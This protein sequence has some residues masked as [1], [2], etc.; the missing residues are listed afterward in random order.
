MLLHDESDGTVSDLQAA[1]AQAIARCCPALQRLDALYSL[2]A[3]L[4]LASLQ[5]LTQLQ[6][7]WP[8]DDREAEALVAL[9]HLQHLELF[10]CSPDSLPLEEMSLPVRMSQLT[11]LSLCHRFQPLPLST[12]RHACWH[13]KPAGAAL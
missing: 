10:S 8:S 7:R 5:H 4:E 2:S 12:S 9:T 1:D 13:D 6:V 11:Q 3:C